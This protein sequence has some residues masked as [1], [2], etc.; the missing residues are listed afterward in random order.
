MGYR[1]IIGI[2]GSAGTGKSSLALHLSQQLGLLVRGEAMRD[3]L[4]QGFDFH[5]LTRAGHRALLAGD[6]EDLARALA[7]G[8]GLITDRTPLDMAAF[9]LTNGFG[10]EDPVATEALLARAICAMADYSLV[11]LL[12]WAALPLVDDGVRSANPW[13]QLH[14]HTVLEGLCRRYVAPGR[15]LVL[16]DA[17]LPVT[18]RG[19]MVR[20][21]LG[22]AAPLN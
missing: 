2:T 4:A 11:V 1:R 9:W 5:N 16:A 6:T 13:M 17:P 19:D 21:R 7:R 3:R 18:A 20:L 22:H 14:F 15:L 12:P 8:D 10:V